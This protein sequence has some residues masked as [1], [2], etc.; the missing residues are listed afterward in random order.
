MRRSTAG[1]GW[2]AKQGEQKKRAGNKEVEKKTPCG[3]VEV[4]RRLVAWRSDEGC[5][6]TPATL[7]LR[8]TS[9]SFVPSTSHQSQHEHHR[10]FDCAS[11]MEVRSSTVC[12]ECMRALRQSIRGKRQGYGTPAAQQWIKRSF[13]A[14]P[15][16]TALKRRSLVV[17]CSEKGTQRRV[18]SASGRLLKEA[19]TQD[20]STLHN[21]IFELTTSALRPDDGKLPT[22]QRVLY[23]LEQLGSIANGLI[24]EQS[25]VNAKRQ[26]VEQETT[27]TSALLGSVNARSYPAFIS[28]A[29]LL[30]LV[31]EK[32]EEIVRDRNIF[33]TPAIL[34]TYV[35]LQAMLHHPSS[36]P[37]ILA[38][39]ASKPVPTE[40]NSRTFEYS[41]PSP[42]APN[43]AVESDT[44]NI[45]LKA[46]IHAHNLPLCLDIISTTFATPS[47]K[48]AK[49]IRRALIP[50]TLLTATP[51]LAY[52][53]SQQFAMLQ[54]TMD[55]SYATGIAFAG[56][57][58]YTSVVG[59]LGYI[60]ITTTNDQMDRVTWAKGVPL[61]ERW[62]RE[63]ERAAL[64]RVAGKWGFQ[65]LEKRGEEE[66]VE[67]ETLREEVGMRGMV[68]DRAELMEGME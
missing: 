25:M 23:V 50:S 68:L 64:D 46:A 52:T 17:E 18:F 59:T 30:N 3:L 10:R 29:A 54:T 6:A 39:Y 2:T 43:S 48:R 55:P 61:W 34:K 47:F 40:T 37:D 9:F 14:S 12:R 33:I 8:A 15:Q 36:F 60:V 53:A 4:V 63:E 13:R 58:T 45:A 65:S 41:P 11:E 21:R 32:A 16:D 38:L 44:A 57:M 42:N 19:Q 51:I 27:A 35:E 22:E 49:F 62:V 66:G 26:R 1:G 20:L 5:A 56:I 31:S 24:D 7:K 67:W 28:K